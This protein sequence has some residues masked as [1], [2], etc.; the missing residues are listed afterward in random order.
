[1]S[2]FGGTND[3][4]AA[5]QLAAQQANV[6]TSENEINQNFAGFTPAFYDQAAT[7]YTNAVTPGNQENYQATKNNLTYALAR[8]GIMNSGAAVQRDNSLSKTLSSSNS[9]IANNAQNQSNTLEANVNS[10]KGQLVNQAVAGTDPT[11]ISSMASGAASQLRA[12][13]A[14]Q[15]LGNLFADWSNTYLAG[16]A[17]QAY[18]SPGTMSLWN[19][20]G[21][22]G[23][24]TV[25]TGTSGGNNMGSGYMVN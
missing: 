12:P 9:Q 4:G 19:Q 15:P 11:A 16:Q 1:M 24:G 21:N 5:A 7:D 17:A 10:Q 22:I 2:L 25:G 20:L 13:S 23:Y 14:I 8:A 6:K 3:G 18:Q